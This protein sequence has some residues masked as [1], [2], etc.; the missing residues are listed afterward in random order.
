MSVTLWNP[1]FPES[2]P[3]C[4]TMTP[5]VDAFRLSCARCGRHH[6]HVSFTPFDA[7]LLAATLW[8]RR[9]DHVSSERRSR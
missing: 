3:A 7:S 4:V 6:D 1:T 9:H 2:L 8:A 5:D